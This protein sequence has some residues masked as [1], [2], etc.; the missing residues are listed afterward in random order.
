MTQSV[1]RRRGVAALGALC[2]ATTLAGGLTWAGQARAQQAKTDLLTFDS[3]GPAPASR[4]LTLPGADEVIVPTITPERARLLF[5]KNSYYPLKSATSLIATGKAST[6]NEKIVGG[7]KAD[8]GAYPFQVAI[9][10]VK[11]GADGSVI[12]QAQFCGG[13]LV[14]SRYVLTAAHCFV[15]GDKGKVASITNTREV[16][17]HVGAVN[18][19]GKADRIPVRRIIS[20]PKYVPGTS[21]NDIALL[22]LE[23][24]PSDA[25]TYERVTVVTRD[26]EPTT[27]PVGADLTIVGWGKMENGK[28]SM[29]LLQSTVNAVDRNACNRALTAARLQMPDAETALADLSFTFNMSPIARKSIEQG[30]IQAAGTVTPQMICAAAPVDGKDTCPGDSGGPI[31]RR[32]PDGKMVQVGIVSFGIGDCGMTALPGVYTRLSLYVDWIKQVVAAPSPAVIP[33]RARPKG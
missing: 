28:S 30:I 24:P 27:L 16:G 2:A 32:Y 17:V 8:E 7:T 26:S 6:A 10:K 19:L 13:T 1:M 20:H 31:L 29:D 18:L 15:Q 3:A 33:I 11:R 9:L 22:E 4:P 23:R 12:P 5:K 25:V 21:V 14:T